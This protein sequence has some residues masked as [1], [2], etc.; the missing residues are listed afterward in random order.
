MRKAAFALR[1]FNVETS[2]AMDVAFD[3]KIVLMRL[4]WWKE[5][6]DEIFSNKLIE[7]PA[8]INDA[9]R[10]VND[11]PE[12]LEELECYAEDTASTIL[13]STLQSG[14]ITSIVVDHAA[15]H[16][17]KASGLLL[18][19]KSLSYHASKNRHFPYTPTE[20][21]EKHRLLKARE[22]SGTIPTEAR[23]VLLPDV[24]AEVILDTLRRVQFER[25]ALPLHTVDCDL[26]VRSGIEM[27]WHFVNAQRPLQAA[28]PELCRTLNSEVVVFGQVIGV[29]GCR[30]Y[31]FS[32]NVTALVLDE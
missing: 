14:G 32:Y 29:A 9:N 3:P 13:Y 23:P 16:I 4:L 22:L 24:T 26:R 30:H 28:K 6:I 21:A 5:A 1:A 11:I 27:L 25:R 7:H 20:V 12:T 17:S 31:V 18:L 2:R 8:R 19:L 15:S 10:E